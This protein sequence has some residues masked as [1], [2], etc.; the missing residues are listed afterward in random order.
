MKVIIAGSRTIKKCNIDSIVKQ[1]GFSI[2]TL[3]CGMAKGVDK[4]GYDWAKN[5]G[6]E[7]DMYPADWHEYGKKAGA[8]RNKKMAEVAEALIAVWDSESKGTKMMIDM[9]RKLDKPVYITKASL[10]Y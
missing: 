6:I 9:M 8:I 3:I 7:I 5:L 2:T 1:S 4:L 10:E